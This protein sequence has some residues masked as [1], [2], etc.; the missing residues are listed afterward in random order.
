MIA[1]VSALF[2]CQVP[3]SQ[4]LMLDGAEYLVAPPEF[5][6]RTGD[7][8][9]WSRDSR[10]IVFETGGVN[11]SLPS[12]RKKLRRDGKKILDRTQLV[13]YDTQTGRIEV[14]Q[15]ILPTDY[16]GA[17]EVLGE[18]GDV[19][20]EV[21][22]PAERRAVFRQLWYAP[23]GQAARRISDWQAVSKSSAVTLGRTAL[24]AY[25]TDDQLR[26]FVLSDESV[27]E[28][29]GLEKYRSGTFLGNTS[30]GSAVLN[31]DTKSPGASSEYLQIVYGS[32]A[33]LP[34]DF[35]VVE[36]V[37]AIRAKAPFRVR[38]YKLPKAGLIDPEVRL[39]NLEL[40][41]KAS[42]PRSLV[43]A[44]SVRDGYVF[45]P[46]GL[47]LAFETPQGF[48]LSELLKKD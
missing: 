2:L 21:K 30:S 44:R 13:R 45:S 42:P 6:A 32:L 41:D 27:R 10:T 31:V 33:V 28:V 36:Y 43:F 37:P 1:I 23:V 11:E 9:Q 34:V 18:S 29:S 20:L 35:D 14:L 48:F 46:D 39:F 16:F 3:A 25:T 19:L 4:S 15:T 26:V 8:I 12:R 22:R 5:I 17:R 24:Y 38:A 40:T 7:A 47:K